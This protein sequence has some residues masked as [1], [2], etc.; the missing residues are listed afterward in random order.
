MKV[1]IPP[2]RIALMNFLNNGMLFFLLI[3]AIVEVASL[4][5]VSMSHDVCS[6]YLEAKIAICIIVRNL[7]SKQYLNL[8]L[9]Q[10]YFFK[11]FLV[12]IFFFV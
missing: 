5:R 12:S 7:H 9:L 10:F 4:I 11:T 8:I 2:N 6:S 3:H 1:S